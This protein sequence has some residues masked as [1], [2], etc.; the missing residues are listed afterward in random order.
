MTLRVSE[1]TDARVKLPVSKNQTEKT[2]LFEIPGFARVVLFRR[3]PSG[4]SKYL[5]SILTAEASIGRQGSRPLTSRRDWL[6]VFC[7]G[8]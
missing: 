4:A 6:L 8:G 1:E 7:S 2:L 3:S 5:A